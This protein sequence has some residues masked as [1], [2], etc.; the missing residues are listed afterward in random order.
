MTSNCDIDNLIQLDTNS[1][2]H[3]LALGPSLLETSLAP[4]VS[5]KPVSMKVPKFLDY[6]V[7]LWHTQ[8]KA[9]FAIHGVTDQ[10]TMYYQVLASLEPHILQKVTSYVSAPTPHA[11]FQGLVA[12]LDFAF[13]KSDG[14][15]FDCIFNATLG[16]KKPSHLYD[17][18]RRLWLDEYPDKSRML[19]HLFMKKLPMTVSVTLRSYPVDDITSFLKVADAMYDQHCQTNQSRMI[20]LPSIPT[21]LAVKK[22]DYQS[23]NGSP[24][25]YDDGCCYYDSGCWN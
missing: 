5:P 19:R 20:S 1:A 10:C 25:I 17:Y 16:D 11:E 6:A 23:Q 15:K 4:M 13:S 8:C 24:Q 7:D 21:R 14:D 22:S 18:M 12:A 3:D 9:V 2:P